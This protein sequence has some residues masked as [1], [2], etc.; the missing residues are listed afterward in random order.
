MVLKIQLLTTIAIGVLFISC[1]EN[2]TEPKTA[3]VTDVH[4]NSNKTVDALNTTDA[5]VQDG[6][7]IATIETSDFVLKIHK[8]ISF[9]LKPKSYEPFK[10]DPSTKLIALDVSVRNK[11]PTPLN[12]SRILGMTVIKGKSEKNLMATWVV[13]AHEVDYPEPNHQKEYDALWSSS[14]EPNGFHRAILLGINPSKEE[15]QFTL[16]VP[17]NPDF[18]NPARKSVQFSV[19]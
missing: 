3:T 2:K 4:T 14:F 6:S 13:A 16:V 10:V 5:G 15:K 7:A 19:E 12:F 1:S 11:L 9:S 17:E 18:N 8:A